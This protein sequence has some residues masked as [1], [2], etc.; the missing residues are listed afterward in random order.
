MT[1]RIEGSSDRFVVNRAVCGCGTGPL[2]LNFKNGAIGADV[3]IQ[4]FLRRR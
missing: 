4:G 1:G 3:Y 2:L